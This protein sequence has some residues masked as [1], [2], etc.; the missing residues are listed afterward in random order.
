MAR[1][2]LA[3]GTWGRIKRREVE[4]GRWFADCRVRDAD[5]VTR[6]ARR[7]SPG[8]ATDRTGA[9]AERELI[10]HL[11]KRTKPSGDDLTGEST[12]TQLW[13]KYRAQLVVD[14]KAPR[15]LQRYDEVAKFI[16]SG[17]SGVRL[18]EVTT[19][20]VETFLAAVVLA[21]GASNGITTRSVLSGMFGMAVR[22][23]ALEVSPTR[24]TSAIRSTPTAKKK[25]L[26][27]EM[28]AQLLLDI[29]TSP[30]PC[31]EPGKTSRYKTPTV[32]EYC[33]SADIADV[34]TMFAATGGR[35]SEVLALEWSGIDFKARTAR[36]D[37]KVVRHPGVG[38]VRT[39]DPDDPKNTQRT[40]ALP[41]FAIAMLRSRKLAAKPNDMDLVF[42]SSRGGLREPTTFNGQWRR[43]RA[44]L[45]LKWVTGHTFRRTVASLLDEGQM[46]ARVAADQLGHSSPSMTMD[47]YMSRGKV[48]SE[49]AAVLDRAATLP[50]SDGVAR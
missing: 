31:P 50:I 35:E 46:S 27:P 6:R 48:R 26:E 40:L 41:D 14:D 10:Q 12:V 39:S 24:E 20:R 37:G 16:K 17:L 8:T 4:P 45:G 25:S 23:D 47:R 7:Y 42:P 30:K 21:H 44:A 2:P 15:T 22:L 1:P 49:V 19:Q 5:G 11:T 32:A 3:I 13:T 28:L 43:V 38:L 34:I 18:R 36:L 9:A 33:A 29:R